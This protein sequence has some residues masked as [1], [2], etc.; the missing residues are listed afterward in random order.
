MR[1]SG[2]VLLS[3]ALVGLG[4]AVL[5]APPVEAFGRLPT[6]LQADLS[7]S[8][9]QVVAVVHVNGAPMVGVLDART[10]SWRTLQ[11]R[12]ADDTRLRWCRFKSAHRILCG[13]EWTW[14]AGREPVRTA[15]LLLLDLDGGRAR[16]M[17]R[18][19]D[20]YYRYSWDERLVSMLDD[21]PGGVL[22]QLGG[23]SEDGGWSV[24][25]MDVGTGDIRAHT[26]GMP[27]A[28]RLF[29]DPAGSVRLMKGIHGNQLTWSIREGP[30]ERWR[31]IARYRPFGAEAVEFVGFGAKP[32]E[33]YTVRAHEGRDALWFEDR[34]DPDQPRLLFSHPEVDVEAPVFWNDRLVGVAFQGERPEIHFVDDD[35]RALFAKLKRIVPGAYPELIDES[36]DGRRLLVRYSADRQPPVYWL[37]DRD[38][39]KGS[40]VARA[41]PDLIPDA[42]GVMN[43]VS[44]PARDGTRVPGYLTLPAGRKPTG[45]PLVVLPHDVL[46]YIVFPNG[47]ICRDVWG[48][49]FLQQFLVSRGYA[50][51]QPEYRGSCGYGNAW[52][53]AARQGWGALPYDDV[54]DG[55]RWAIERGIAD[56]NRVAIV[57]RGHGGSLALLG[58]ERDPELFRAAIAIG[59]VADLRVLLGY[60]AAHFT[61]GLYVLR[62]IIGGNADGLIADSPSAHADRVR[63]PILLFHG[64]DDVEVPVNQSRLMSAALRRA[65]KDHELVVF[66]KETHEIDHEENRIE[67]LRRIE[68]FLARHLGSTEGEE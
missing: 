68:A 63:A 58:A 38:T 22:V 21:D 37:V 55:V 52:H 67:M 35:A 15:R 56:P 48:F 27:D 36:A 66:P 40:G 29:A 10:G 60:A 51:L 11:A 62:E 19:S 25:R 49:D 44:Y 50:V 18:T 30:S 59:G 5:A 64:T 2:F 20:T 45:L 13:L 12:K 17:T 54:V 23:E 31:E 9:D 42:L 53:R 43:G 26:R 47:R 16:T 8:G 57:G 61:D 24:F 4:P 28:V 1:I 65:G 39:G 34:A 7:P 32:T 6:I 3:A 33:F 41:Y 46:P 14:S